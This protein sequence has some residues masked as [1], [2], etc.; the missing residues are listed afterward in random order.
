MEKRVTMN[1]I[2]EACRTSIGTVDRALHNRSD[3][4]P[5]TRQFILDTAKKLGYKTN[6]LAGALSRKNNIR[7]AFIDPMEPDAFY[8]CI[9]KG[10][11]QAVSELSPFGIEVD[12]LFFDPHD[13]ESQKTLLS[14]LDFMQYDGI[15]INPQSTACSDF[16]E[17][18]TEAGIPTATFNND[19]P[20]SPRL[21]YVGV[22]SG[23]SGR[24]AGDI[25]GTITNGHGSIAIIGNYMQ[26]MPFFERFQ[27]FCDVIRQHYPGISIYPSADCQLDLALTKKN[28]EN[29]LTAAPDINGIF[30]T[31][32]FSTV[33]T[34][35]ALRELNRTD[36]KLIG[37]DISQD[38]LQAIKDGSCQVLLY[39]D[40]Y[41]QGYQTIQLLAKHILDG[42]KPAENQI[43][44][45]T[46]LVFR[47]NIDNY[48]SGISR[49][50][51]SLF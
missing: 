31:S 30:C 5:E 25:M 2:A 36:I 35:R 28:L 16:I 44:I 1:M 42:W 17:C 46:R 50:D 23:Q 38:G 21:F 32:Y 15:A 34:I 18:F 41:Q 11:R 6:K 9:H 40:P 27:G 47:Q 51:C 20:N 39:Q 19:L 48:S 13:P 12:F 43:L 4:N 33:G 37:Y 8:G 26:I 10:V 24:M 29:L 45:E 22:D 14:K 3:I 49:W 7:I